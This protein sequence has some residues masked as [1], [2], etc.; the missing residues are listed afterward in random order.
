MKK[1]YTMPVVV[2]K[3]IDAEPMLAGSDP[4]DRMVSATVQDDHEDNEFAKQNTVDTIW[5]D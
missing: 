2:S 4:M 3:A 5:D 1:E